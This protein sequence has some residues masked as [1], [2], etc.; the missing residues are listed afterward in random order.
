MVANYFDMAFFETVTSWSNWHFC[1]IGRLEFSSRI[2]LFNSSFTISTKP[3]IAFN[4]HWPATW[5][6]RLIVFLDVSL[7]TLRFHVMQL[8]KHC[9]YFNVYF[10]SH[11]FLRLSTL[12]VVTYLRKLYFLKLH[13]LLASHA[14][15]CCFKISKNNLIKNVTLSDFNTN[16]TLTLRPTLLLLF[17]QIANLYQELK[18]TNF[19]GN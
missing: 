18:K 15:T 2:V 10:R 7:F 9:L 13:D 3:L 19:L 8:P 16:P 12:L 4:M 14:Y 5:V 17:N 6:F 1:Q 11:Y